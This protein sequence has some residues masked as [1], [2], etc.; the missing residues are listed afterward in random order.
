SRTNR[1][2]NS[3]ARNWISETRS[4]AQQGPAFATCFPC[5][6]RARRET[7]D[8]RGV[9]L[10]LVPQVFNLR[11]ACALPQLHL[12]QVTNLRHVVIAHHEIPQQ[13]VQCIM[14]EC[15]LRSRDTERDV[16]DARKGPRVSN[17][18]R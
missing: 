6:P 17:P 2:V 7:R 4:V 5:V 12:S 11:F 13:S 10:G 3:F 1:V 16:V 14:I 9:T 15:V 8:P 18:L